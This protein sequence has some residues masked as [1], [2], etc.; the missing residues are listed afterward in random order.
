MPAF[1]SSRVDNALGLNA[2]SV[3]SK[4]I[5]TCL[6]AIQVDDIPLH[7]PGIIAA[8]TVGSS[9]GT[10]QHSL[11]SL[12]PSCHAEIILASQDGSRKNASDPSTCPII[13]NIEASPVPVCKASS[14]LVCSIPSHL[15][16]LWLL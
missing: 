13:P 9:N 1:Q 5:M 3:I 10:S 6:P 15:L 16:T 11:S 14:I 7:V 4:S 8:G 2:C 12:D